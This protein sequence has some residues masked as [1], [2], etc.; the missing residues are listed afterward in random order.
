MNRIFS[1]TEAAPAIDRH[2]GSQEE[3]RL[4]YKEIMA[5][6]GKVSTEAERYRV[7]ASDGG[8]YETIE[9]AHRFIFPPEEQA[10]LK[11]TRDDGS[12]FDRGLVESKAA[13]VSMVV[14]AGIGV[15]LDMTAEPPV[16]TTY[17]VSPRDGGAS[18]PLPLELTDAL[19]F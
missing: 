4:R 11:S 2:S 6:L 12:Y 17:D 10:I 9:A 15:E 18:Q 19:A 3:V 8:P 14:E 16:V 1:S 13:K 5:N 7:I